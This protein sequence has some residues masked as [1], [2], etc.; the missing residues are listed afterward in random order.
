MSPSLATPTELNPEA[1]A[2]IPTPNSTTSTLCSMK[3]KII[4]L[5]TARTMVHDPLKPDIA[6][7]VHLLFNSGSQRSYV[8]EWAMK[9]L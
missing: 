6:V 7:E 3:R 8:M 9:L 4:L 2:Y 1:P 5:Q